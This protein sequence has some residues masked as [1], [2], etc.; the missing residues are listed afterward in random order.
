MK[1]LSIIFQVLLKSSII[2]LIFYIWL[3]YI[4]QSTWLALVV[5]F[6][7]ALLL[8]LISIYVKRKKGIKSNLKVKEKEDAEN[9]FFTL[10]RD[11]NR[12]DF[13]FKLAKTRHNNVNKFKRYIIVH[14][15][16][17][18]DVVLYPFIKYQNLKLDDVIDVLNSFKKPINKL[19][20]LCNDYDKDL[21]GFVK[22]FNQEIIILN[23]YQT[24]LSLYKEYDYYPAI[25]E[26]QKTKNSYK[27]YLAVAFNRSKTKGYLFAV[28]ILV[29]SSF[30]VKFNIYYYIISSLLL[31]LALISFINPIYNKKIIKELL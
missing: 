14:H 7:I 2:F 25:I 30:F 19:V 11:E 1:T 24:Y 15:E 13:F 28:V 21:P 22:N 6:V 3:K 29:L 31:I 8:E 4:F 18:Q 12:V 5:S 27:Q 26:R 23:K 17:G 20:I 9:M 10:S 16:G